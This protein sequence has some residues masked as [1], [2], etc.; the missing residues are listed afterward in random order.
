[1]LVTYRSRQ[2]RQRPQPAIRRCALPMRSLGRAGRRFMEAAPRDSAVRGSKSAARRGRPHGPLLAL[3]PHGDCKVLHL[4]IPHTQ[5]PAGV[6]VATGAAVPDRSRSHRRAVVVDGAGHGDPCPPQRPGRTAVA[7][8]AEE[9]R[10]AAPIREALR[11]APP[12]SQ[13][14]TPVRP[15]ADDECG[16][17]RHPR[18]APRSPASRTLDMKPASTEAMASPPRLPSGRGRARSQADGFRHARPHS[19]R[20][21]PS[22]Q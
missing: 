20:L 4:H 8:R 22:L 5:A 16:C 19:D 10:T 1:M 3:Q 12:T 2:S 18:A 15:P 11:D 14:Q 17:R 6:V 13:T 7:A 9:S 21:P